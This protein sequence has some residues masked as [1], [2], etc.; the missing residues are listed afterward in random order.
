M[1]LGWTAGQKVTVEGEIR[2]GIERGRDGCSSVRTPPS[3]FLIPLPYLCS[4]LMFKGKK[5]SE[6]SLAVAG[7][8]AHFVFKRIKYF[9]RCMRVGL[10]PSIK[11][12]FRECQKAGRARWNR[13]VSANSRGNEAGCQVSPNPT[14]AHHHSE[15]VDF[16]VQYF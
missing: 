9:S 10:Y 14:L 2:N 4:R 11:A 8:R 1:N 5:N 15:F 7:C 16:W 6:C 3:S 13:R 12:F